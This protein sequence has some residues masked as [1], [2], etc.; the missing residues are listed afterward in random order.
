MMFVNKNTLINDVW[1]LVIKFIIYMLG[2][3]VND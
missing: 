1:S 2:G 3:G